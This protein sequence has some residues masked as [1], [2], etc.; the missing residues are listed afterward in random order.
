M[1][2]SF[3]IIAFAIVIGLVGFMCLALIGSYFYKKSKG[4]KWDE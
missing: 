1:F 3:P 4:R 2:D